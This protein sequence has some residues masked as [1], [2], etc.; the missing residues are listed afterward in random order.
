MNP[1]SAGLPELVFLGM[2]VLLVYVL[3]RSR[4]RREAEREAQRVDLQARMLER[5]GSPKEFGEF[6]RTS[7]GR[8]FLNEL[9][10]HAGRPVERAL[11]FVRGGLVAVILGPAFIV[12]GPRGVNIGII[13]VF[14]GVGMLVAAGVSYWFARRLGMVD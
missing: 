10:G 8:R 3:V 7:E 2:L 5:M 12:T 4:T 13:L 14:L 6:L 11:A 9:G 1:S